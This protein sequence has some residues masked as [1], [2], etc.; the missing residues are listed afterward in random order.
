MDDIFT[1]VVS[2]PDGVDEMVA[3]CADGWTIYLSDRLD[4]ETMKKKHQHALR[5]IRGNDWEKEDIQ[6]IEV[7][8]HGIR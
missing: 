6:E 4:R 5:H 8:A 2:L 3:P 1:Y 7:D